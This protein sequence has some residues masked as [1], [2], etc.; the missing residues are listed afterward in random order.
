[1]TQSNICRKGFILSYISC[2]KSSI[3]AT[4]GGN[5][6]AGSW[7]RNQGGIQMADLHIGLCSVSLYNVHAHL[8]RERTVLSGMELHTS[9]KT[10]PHRHC[11]KVNV[12]KAVLQLSSLF[13]GN[14]SLSQ[15]DN[16]NLPAETWVT[17]LIHTKRNIEINSFLV[18]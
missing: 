4:Q 5:S 1:M 16:K 18:F 6:K 8:L 10:M 9:I 14:S 17:T 11:P 2:S 7:S 15:V 13:P 12:I 3:E